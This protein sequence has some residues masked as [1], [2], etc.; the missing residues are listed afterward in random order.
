MQ[1]GKFLTTEVL[2]AN[3]NLIFVNLV[4]VFLVGWIV[5]V[6]RDYYA[7]FFKGPVNMSVDALDARGRGKREVNF[8][9]VSGDKSFQSVR[10]A[11]LLL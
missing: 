7:S 2:R 10:G 8:V 1:L 5:F 4:S 9:S 6:S 11:G 3:R